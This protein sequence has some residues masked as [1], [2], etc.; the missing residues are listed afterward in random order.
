MKSKSSTAAAL[1]PLPFK[2]QRNIGSKQISAP[3]CEIGAAIRKH[4][5]QTKG[6]IM[7]NDKATVAEVAGGGG[8][9][10]RRSIAA[11]ETVQRHEGTTLVPGTPTKNHNTAAALGQ[12]WASGIEEIVKGTL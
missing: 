10:V 1:C 3:L 11:S 12:G 4:L 8:E 7:T 9:A 5:V 6:A 2:P